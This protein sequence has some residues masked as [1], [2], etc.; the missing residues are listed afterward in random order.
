MI[1]S[2]EVTNYL[3]ESIKLMLNRPEETGI[4]IHDI[5][6]L[7]P[8]KADINIGESSTGDGGT[9]NSSRLQSRNITFGLT[10]LFAPTIEKVRHLTYKYFPIKKRVKLVVETDLRTSE[11]YGYVESNDPDIFSS[12]QTTQIS[13]I[14]PD[15]YFYSRKIQ[16]TVFSGV[17]ALFEFPF[18]NES[19]IEPLIEMSALQVEQQQTVLYEGDAEVGITIFIHAVGGATNL[20]IYNVNTRES[21][22]IS[23]SRLLELTGD[24]IHAGDDITISTV[25]GA[26]SVTLYRDGEYFNILN[27]LD[28][29]S[30]WFSL[31]R[32]DNVLLYTADEGD[33]NLQFRIE[34]RIAYEGV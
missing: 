9:Y 32:G 33:S 25:R 24:D 16:N 22:S 30:D 18:S 1:K 7:G 29:R 19:L 6:G 13:I 27:C 21:M 2:I 20:T 8:G 31:T 12:K 11:I 34:N 26:K 4:V 23:S 17:E 5:Q 10:F 3:G 15:P 28:R 14:C